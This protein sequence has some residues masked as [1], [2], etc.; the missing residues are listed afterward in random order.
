RAV[1]CV[2][3]VWPDPVH[4][5]KEP[6]DCQLERALVGEECVVQNALVFIRRHF[7]GDSSGH[8]A[9]HTLRVWRAARTLRQREGG[10]RLVIELAALLHDVDDAK[11]F[12]THDSLAH[13]RAFLAENQVDAETTRAVCEAIRTVSFK[14]ADTETPAT[15]EGQIVQDADRLDAIGAIGVARAFAYGGSRGRAMY[16]PDQ[17]WRGELTA[18]QY[19]AQQG[20]TINHFY[21]KLFKLASLM[22]TPSARALAQQRHAFMQGYLA[23]FLEEWDGVR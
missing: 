13:A 15:L 4:V 23:E 14:G 16:D 19:A 6:C 9:F 18:E 2:E 10:N 1:G 5:E 11:L 3:A 12:D 8:D 21:E 22:N 20:T 17:P 7:R